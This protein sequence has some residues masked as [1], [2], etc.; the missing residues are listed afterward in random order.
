MENAQNLVAIISAELP[1]LHRK[2]KREREREIEKEI[3]RVESDRVR[4]YTVDCRSL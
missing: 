1:L 4:K 2:G 3:E